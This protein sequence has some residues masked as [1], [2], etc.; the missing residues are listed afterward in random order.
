MKDTS[1]T[2]MWVIDILYAG[3][4]W[5]ITHMWVIDILLA[6][7]NWKITHMW[8]LEI[9]YIIMTACHGS[10]KESTDSKVNHDRL[11]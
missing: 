7:G 1:I 3:G 9:I 6:G 2:H 8:V 10:A 11:P 5:K 4:N